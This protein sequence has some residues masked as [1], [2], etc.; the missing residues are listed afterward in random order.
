VFDLLKLF[1]MQF[2]F[3]DILMVD[4]KWKIS[5]PGSVKAHDVTQE[6]NTAGRGTKYYVPVETIQTIY[7]PF[8]DV[9]SLAAITGEL[10]I[11]KLHRDHVYRGKYFEDN[12][13]F[14]HPKVGKALHRLMAK[15]TDKDYTK[16]PDAQG[17]LLGIQEMMVAMGVEPN[18][19]KVS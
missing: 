16:R 12:L 5:D 2:I 18:D 7:G 14:H 4:G 1:L 13:V 19:T 8:T 10:L 3:Q 11:G 15:A 6:D 17:F 9:Y